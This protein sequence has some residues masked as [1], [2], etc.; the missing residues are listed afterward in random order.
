MI[1][2]NPKEN[3]LKAN[4]LNMCL[5]LNTELLNRPKSVAIPSSLKAAKLDFNSDLVNSL[6]LLRRLLE[7]RYYCKKPHHVI[8]QKGLLT[9]CWGNQR[10]QPTQ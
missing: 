8:V 4:Q 2:S 9:P 6:T 7:C 1:S 10:H 3:Y 5:T